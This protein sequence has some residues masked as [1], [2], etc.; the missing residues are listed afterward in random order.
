MR[1]LLGTGNTA[2]DPNNNRGFD[3]GLEI[4]TGWRGRHGDDVRAFHFTLSS[5]RPLTLDDFAN[6]DFGV[7]VAS[8][9]RDRNGDGT[10]DTFR[11]G[12]AKLIENS[13]DPL[14]AADDAAGTIEEGATASGNI[15]GNDIGLG[16]K[17]LTGVSYKGT[18][19]QFD[20]TGPLVIALTDSAGNAT[21]ATAAIFADGGYTIDATQAAALAAGQQVDFDITYHVAQTV[22]ETDG[23]LAGTASAQAQLTGAL[24]GRGS[25]PPFVYGSGEHPTTLEDQP[26]FTFFGI[27]DDSALLTVTLTADAPL[28]LDSIAGLTFLEGDGAADET[29]T[30][31]GSVGDINMAL[32]AVMY[33]PRADFSGIGHIAHRVDDG[34]NVVEGSLDINIR[35][36]ADEPVF[37]IAAP[38]ASTPLPLSGEF[39]VDSSL[40]NTARYASTIAALEDGGFVIAWNQGDAGIVVRRFGANQQPIG[41]EFAVDG[42][43][44]ARNPSIAALDGGGFVVT[45]SSFD[46]AGTGDIFGQRF[47]SAGTAL[48]GAFQIN[49]TMASDQQGVAVAALDG[50]GFVATWLSNLQDGDSLGVYGQRY[51]AAGAPVGG[52]FLINTTTAGAQF[53]PAVAARDGGGFVV[54][55]TQNLMPGG[56]PGV[57]AQLYDASGAPQGAE[58][59]VNTDA[60]VSP[61][62][63]GDVARRW[64]LR[65]HVRP[66]QGNFSSDIHGRLY[67]AL[68]N[69]VGDEFVV[70]LNV[71]P[72]QQ[73]RRPCRRCPTAASWSRGIPCCRTTRRA[74][75]AMASMPSDSMRTGMRSAP[76]SASTRPAAGDQRIAENAFTNGQHAFAVLTPARSSRPGRASRSMRSGRTFT[77]APS[78]SAASTLRKST[79]HFAGHHGRGKRYRRL[80]NG[81]ACALRF[82]ARHGVLGRLARQ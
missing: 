53:L 69:P 75:S 57:F 35:P 4:G 17:V 39:A 59:A 78:P 63:H 19:F 12:G 38:G 62:R 16:T 31:Q 32:L 18:T 79:R 55:W 74:S 15:L 61:V 1:G 34:D 64:R 66:R 76:N 65:R 77:R 73:L 71:Q 67:D 82:P 81:L 23:S 3:V 49:T 27:V 28:W 33:A 41:S 24:L 56:V 36:V 51:D 5:D 46:Q 22:L 13:F 11:F 52:E 20:G 8:I 25:E 54:T 58:F 70:A 50:G 10:I 60:S 47:S 21:G 48:G 26:T 43:A 30:F 6:V 80:R 68:G 42:A 7:R 44:T 45:W 37:T 14:N 29:M 9:G 40:S 2:S 72:D